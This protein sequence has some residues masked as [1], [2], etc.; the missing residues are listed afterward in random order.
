MR[1][2]RTDW[3]WGCAVWNS[4]IPCWRRSDNMD[5]SWRWTSRCRW[6]WAA[7]PGRRWC[8]ARW[9]ARSCTAA[10]PSPG[11]PMLRGAGIPTKK[12]QKN[13]KIY[14]NGFFQISTKFEKNFKNNVFFFFFSYIPT[15]FKK[16]K[17]KPLFFKNSKI[18]VFFSIFLKFQQNSKN[19]KKN[20]YFFRTKNLNCLQNLQCR[21]RQCCADCW[22][23]STARKSRGSCDAATSDSCW[24]PT[25]FRWATGM[26]T[27]AADRRSRPPESQSSVADTRC[28]FALPICLQLPWN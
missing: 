27:W 16:K 20:R 5:S 15:K 24:P 3:D 4:A 8:S 26:A 6:A 1:G 2:K 17:K 22:P 7:C 19:L 11:W 10:S 9:A 18:T 21:C 23:P 14:N 25:W 28:S 12:F 13:K